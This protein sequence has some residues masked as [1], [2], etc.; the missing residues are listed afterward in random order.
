MSF[1]YF[2]NLTAN[3]FIDLGLHTREI[4]TRRF[5]RSIKVVFFH[6]SFLGQLEA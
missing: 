2:M 3:T 6:Q 1:Y 5:S 4:L